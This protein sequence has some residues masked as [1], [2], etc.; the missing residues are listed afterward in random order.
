MNT[1][2]FF[3]TIL[4]AQGVYY[5]G[6]MQAGRPGVG[7]RSYT[8]LEDMARAVAVFDTKPDVTV[9]HACGTYLQTHI[10]GVK[11][12]GT[13]T[14]LYRVGA[15]TNAAKALWADLDCGAEKA[16]AG[17]GYAT[18]SDA[19]RAILLFCQKTGFPSPLLV[20]SGNGIHAYW[21]FTQAI[22]SGDWKAL[23]AQFKAA[24]AHFGVIADPTRT[25]DFASI[26][27]PVGSANKKDPANHKMVKVLREAPEVDISVI[28]AA[29]S[30]I[31]SNFDV[32]LLGVAPA[33]A[34]DENDDLTGHLAPSIPS[35]ANIVASKCGQVDLVRQ[36]GGSDYQQWFKVIGVLKH[37][38]N[39]NDAAH[40]WS[41]Q[42]AS[43]THA[44]TEQKFDSWN[45]GPSTCEAFEKINASGCEGC[46]FKGKVKTPLVL[47]RIEV[48][49]EPSKLVE[50]KIDGEVVQVMVPQMPERYS[51]AGHGSALRMYR[52]VE[53]KDGVL[54]KRPFAYLLFYPTTRICIEDGTFCLRVRVHKPKGE[55]EEFDI[56]SST[57]AVGGQTLIT[58]LGKQEIMYTTN[59][60]AQSHITAYMQESLQNLLETTRQINT[61][62]AFGWQ[63]N[64][65]SF[66]LGDRL[67][68][69]DGSVQRVIL[70]GHALSRSKSLPSPH[71][72]A[73]GWTDGV[74]TIYN[75]DGMQPMQYA[76]CSA[77]GSILTPFGEDLY[78]G[79]PVALTGS[80]SGKGKTT[81][82]HAALYAFGDAT[83][84]SIN[85]PKG[86]TDNARWAIMGAMRNIPMLLDEI[87]HIKAQD[88]SEMLFAASNGQ[89]KERMKSGAKGVV[90]ADQNT[91]DMSMFMTANKHLSMVLA[92]E[93]ANTESESVRFIE[94]QTDTYQIPAV[95]TLVVGAATM[96]I[97]RN[98]G[99][100]GAEFVQYVVREVDS[101]P[102]R[103]IAMAK[104]L[105][106]SSKVSSNSQ[107][108]YYRQHAVCTLVAAEIMVELGLVA[109]DTEALFNW[110]ILHITKICADVVEF[111][112]LTGEEATQRMLADMAPMVITTASY[113]DGR[114][115]VMPE[116][117]RLNVPP[118]GRYITGTS[119]G[120]E[121]L[122][123]HVFI[124]KAAVRDWCLKNRVDLHAI[125]NYL[126]G[127]G[128]M[129]SGSGERFNVTKGT[130]M[131]PTQLVCFN[132]DTNRMTDSLSG[133]PFL[134]L[135][136][137]EIENAA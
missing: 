114:V 79:I 66:L 120:S 71:G 116:T 68:R 119:H 36:T 75:R 131:P 78:H 127:I 123:G 27:R 65:D 98:A 44:E 126:I 31:V 25:A 89:D 118:V 85:G 110:T 96:K 61:M 1:L 106:F 84:M 105:A 121:P 81:V 94:I 132:I 97:S 95:D 9:Y 57:V 128:A 50:A 15:N 111:N 129:P 135:H 54:T 24:L 125:P 51:H 64:K 59:K 87:T 35:D 12:D 88:L 62:T 3:Q 19:G 42:S 21:P 32:D 29:L 8:S 48:P 10:D 22:S 73:A 37:C 113:K 14:K 101:I 41:E 74:N 18:K 53:N 130:T 124:S 115:G 55:I 99:C 103:F 47:G 5:L 76:L 134:T 70:G 83:K 108:R 4:P 133:V 137:T 136:Q 90:I 30:N 52:D 109:F 122:A 80:E 40:Q 34:T 102:D 38:Q 26:L 28:M 20:D 46:A 67:Y 43:Y 107:Y 117:V 91:W 72:T 16:A 13:P 63:A 60:D 82:C 33:Y 56:P 49:A 17:K 58:E 6:L 2:Q 11:K 92:S 93:K 100:S 39:G 7:H 45:A 69:K 104:R 23:A 112:T 77:F 86:A